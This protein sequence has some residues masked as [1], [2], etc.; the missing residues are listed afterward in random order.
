[1]DSAVVKKTVSNGKEESLEIPVTTINWDR[2]LSL[3]SQAEINKPA[4][5]E[6]YI[7]ETSN[8]ITTYRTDND[9]M[10]VQWIMI[11]TT[12]GDT[13]EINIHTHTE[14]FLSRSDYMLFYFPGK[15][16]TI[17]GRQEPKFFG[18]ERIF[19][20]TATLL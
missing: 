1:M 3:F 8:G 19:S 15:G 6:K 12:G 5:R 11:F 7:V 20:I 10:K 4:L 16:Y 18:E 13:T 9:K 17:E 14:N 2:E